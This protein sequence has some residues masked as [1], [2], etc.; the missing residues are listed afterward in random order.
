MRQ[1][2][3]MVLSPTLSPLNLDRLRVLDLLLEEDHHFD[4][5]RR[6]IDLT[7]HSL[8]VLRVSQFDIPPEDR[9]ECFPIQHLNSITVEMMD[10]HFGRITLPT[11]LSIFQWWIRHF[12]S[13]LDMQ[14]SCVHFVVIT[15]TYNIRAEADYTAWRD[16]DA[17]L[18]QC[19]VSSLTIDVSA[20]EGSVVEELLNP[21]SVQLAIEQNLPILMSRKVAHVQILDTCDN[22]RGVN[23]LAS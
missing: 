3:E 1:I 15:P 7:T 17:V 18:S 8:E 21:I 2:P 14:C 12:E 9:S 16:R 19:S 6:F 10:Y 22:D 11:E 23:Y 20:S 5:A 4:Q 13:Y